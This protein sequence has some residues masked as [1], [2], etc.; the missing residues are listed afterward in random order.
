MTGQE[1]HRFM[2][3]AIRLANQGLAAAVG[4]QKF[5]PEITHILIPGLDVC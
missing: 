1:Q 3:R 5:I 2:A 4:D